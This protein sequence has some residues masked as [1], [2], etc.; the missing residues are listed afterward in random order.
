MCSLNRNEY[1]NLKLARDTIGTGLGRNEEDW[2]RLMHIS[3]EITQGTF[4]CSS[5]Y[6]KLTKASCF[7]FIFFCFFFYKIRE[8]KGRT[9]SVGWGRLAL[10]GAERRQGKG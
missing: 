2:K 3:K 7:S 1:R 6:L 8:Q 10:V 9:G 5:L 4:L